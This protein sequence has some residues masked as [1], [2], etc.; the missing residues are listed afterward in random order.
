MD[1]PPPEH[2]S[3]AT[4]TRKQRRGRGNSGS[5]APSPAASPAKA[6]G[7]KAAKGGQG[8]HGSHGGSSGNARRPAH[9]RRGRADSGGSA[10]A[11]AADDNSPGN[12]FNQFFV[13]TS[14]LIHDIDSALCC[15]LRGSWRCAAALPAALPPAAC[16]RI[17]PPPRAR[18]SRLRRFALCIIRLFCFYPILL[19]FW[20]QVRCAAQSH[21]AP[22]PPRSMPAERILVVVQEQGWPSGKCFYGTLRSFD[23]FTNLVLENCF[24][25]VFVGGSQYGELR[26]GLFV[27]RGEN[28]ILVSQLDTDKPEIDP[29]LS[30]LEWNDAMAKFK[31]AKQARAAAA[32]QSAFVAQGGDD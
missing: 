25:R 16:R 24:E 12:N 17:A 11:A 29:V 30:Q 3:S 21:L 5:A 31:A 28:I 9:E 1:F 32:G 15:W 18:R 4:T 19:L 13:G 7:G 23:Q 22:P 10:A 8:G 14:S 26:R 27:I 6:A 20:T 2:A